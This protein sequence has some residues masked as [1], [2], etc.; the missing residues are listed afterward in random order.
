MDLYDFIGEAL[1]FGN[2][3]FDQLGTYLGSGQAGAGECRTSALVPLV[4]E[5]AGLVKYMTSMLT[6]MHLC[7]EQEEILQPIVDCY[8]QLFSTFGTFFQKCRLNSFLQGL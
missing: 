1:A 7:V 6:A 2:A 3:I 5:S 8:K 4:E